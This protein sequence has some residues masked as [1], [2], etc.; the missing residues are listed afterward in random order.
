MI[1]SCYLRLFIDVWWFC[2]G[3]GFT[4]CGLLFGLSFGLV[5]FL[6]LLVVF[7]FRLLLWFGG[8]LQ[9]F[10]FECLLFCVMLY[11]GWCLVWFT[12]DCAC[13]I[14]VGLLWRVVCGVGLLFVF[15]FG[16]VLLLIVSYDSC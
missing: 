15:A 10:L 9:Y 12:F 14:L 13:L 1:V 2:C 8:V 3:L 16:Y 11:G 6:I 4:C 5:W 7:V